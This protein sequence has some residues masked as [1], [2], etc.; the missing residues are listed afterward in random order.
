M[1]CPLK[2][3]WSA[4]TKRASPRLRCHCYNRLHRRWMNDAAIVICPWRCEHKREGVVLGDKAGSV[5]GGRSAG[6]TGDG[7]YAIAH[8]DPHNH[9]S[10]FDCYHSGLEVIL[11]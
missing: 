10:R 1:N 3:C 8:I 2:L 6:L 9:C 7:M 5:E 11:A 4:N